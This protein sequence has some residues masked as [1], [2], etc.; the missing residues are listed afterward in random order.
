MVYLGILFFTNHQ[1]DN[2]Q[3]TATQEPDK[4]ILG[5]LHCEVT[6]YGVKE[7]CA[8]TNIKIIGDNSSNLRCRPYIYAEERVCGWQEANAWFE[9]VKLNEKSNLTMGCR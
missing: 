3:I 5:R 6:N 4:C 8:V 9:Q 1:V 2:S 7:V